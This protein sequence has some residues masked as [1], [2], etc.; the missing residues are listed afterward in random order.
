[1]KWNGEGGVLC[2]CWCLR[3]GNRDVFGWREVLF[4]LRERL[5]VPFDVYSGTKQ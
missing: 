5:Y 1:M 3:N 2:C 4:H